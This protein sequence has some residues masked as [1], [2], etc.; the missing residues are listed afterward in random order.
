MTHLTMDVFVPNEVPVGS[1]L[2]ARIVNN[3]GG[4]ETS[5][6]AT[7]F[8]NIGSPRLVSGQWVTLVVD[9]RGMADRSNLGQIILAADGDNNIAFRG[10]TFWVD[11]IYLYNADAAN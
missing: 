4:G 7:I 10:Q 9:I 8:Q 6:T 2:L 1:S 3:V 5:A 11:N